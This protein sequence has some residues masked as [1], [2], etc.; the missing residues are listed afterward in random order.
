MRKR[1]NAENKNTIPTKVDED[2]KRHKSLRRPPNAMNIY[3]TLLA[4]DHFRLLTLRPGLGD[5]PLDM[6]L[7]VHSLASV[8][9]YEALSYCWGTEGSFMIT[10]KAAKLEIQANLH[11]ALKALRRMDQDRLMWIDALCINQDD[12]D[13]R[14]SRYSLCGRFI[15][16]VFE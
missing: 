11:R 1:F 16:T 4:P 12:L 3:Q 6:S 7:T 5:D 14:G 2:E 9:S 13:E 10:C 15:K 8:P